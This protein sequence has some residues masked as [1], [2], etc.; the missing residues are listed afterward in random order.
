MDFNGV[1]S[2]PANY[3]ES[4]SRGWY[5]A[6]LLAMLTCFALTLT[7]IVLLYVFYTKVMQ[8]MTLQEIAR[9]SFSLRVWLIITKFALT[10]MF[11]F[12]S[13]LLPSYTV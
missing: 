2:P 11:S 7:G 1:I 10:V 13:H 9:C 6:L 3:E 4:E 8:H 5:A 12:S